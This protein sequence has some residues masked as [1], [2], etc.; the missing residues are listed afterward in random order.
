MAITQ[1]SKIQVRRGVRGDADVPVLDPGELGWAVDTHELFIGNDRSFDYFYDQQSY[2]RT[3]YEPFVPGAE[4]NTRIL[5]THDFNKITDQAKYQFS[6]QSSH[7]VL[8]LQQKL[9]QEIYIE[10]F[11]VN[12][13]LTDNTR[14]FR[15]AV[16]KIGPDR[17][18]YLQP[19]VYEILYTIDVP[20]NVKIKGS[21]KGLT[22]IKSPVRVFNVSHSVSISDLTIV[23]DIEAVAVRGDNVSLTVD[24]DNPTKAGSA[25][26]VEN[27]S[28][29]SVSGT[30]N[31]FDAAISSTATLDKLN[32]NAKL[33]GCNYAIN[34]SAVML[35][36]KVHFAGH[37]EV[38]AVDAGNNEVSFQMVGTAGN[39]NFNGTYTYHNND[40]RGHF[41]IMNGQRWESEYTI[42]S[43]LI[44][45]QVSLTSGWASSSPISLSFNSF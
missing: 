20:A 16:L 1:V 38:I 3:S 37:G 41:V 4:Y 14:D 13:D 25:I 36:S 24:F 23:S 5:T 35:N 32:V 9:E 40:E 8:T 29:L 30:I 11:G 28:N 33:M 22:Y 27:G 2:D 21:G 39:T 45:T 34:T 10:E 26:I 15:Q 42:S 6:G 44:D 19:G 18:L 43:N 7:V 12:R 17:V 31:G